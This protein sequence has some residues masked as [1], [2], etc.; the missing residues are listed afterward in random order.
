MASA[1]DR[2]VVRE[3]VRQRYCDCCLIGCPWNEFPHHLSSELHQVL[4]DLYKRAAR[5]IFEFGNIVLRA[6]E[7]EWENCFSCGATKTPTVV[8]RACSHCDGGGDRVSKN[9]IPGVPYGG[10]ACSRFVCEECAKDPFCS[11][12]A[13]HF[14]PE[15]LYLDSDALEAFNNGGSS[16]FAK[17]RVAV[18]L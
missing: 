18:W 12:C 1:S 14:G 16:P 10:N 11:S 13:S 3:G 9:G 4:C 17:H 5:R 7:G 2:L 8:I 6:N 15:D